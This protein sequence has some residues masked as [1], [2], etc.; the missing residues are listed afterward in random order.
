MA[1]CLQWNTV[2]SEVIN[3]VDQVCSQRRV[4]SFRQAYADWNEFAGV[5]SVLGQRILYI[6]DML[7]FST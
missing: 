3:G 2:K 6:D 4:V 1:V 5:F 7:I